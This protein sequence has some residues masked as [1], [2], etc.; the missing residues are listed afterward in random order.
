MKRGIKNYQIG[1]KRLW[2]KELKCMKQGQEEKAMRLSLK[3]YI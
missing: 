1:N 2:D 3:L